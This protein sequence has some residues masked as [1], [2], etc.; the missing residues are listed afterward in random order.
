M[1][2]RAGLARAAAP[3]VEPATV[4]QAVVASGGQR[5]TPEMV[6]PALHALAERWAR[7]YTGTFAFMVDMREAAAHGLSA[8]Q[9][10]GVLNCLLAD[11]RRAATTGTTPTVAEPTGPATPV[12][13][14]GTYTV[15]LDP[16]NPEH[17]RR[18]LRLRDGFANRPGS[19]VAAYLAGPDNDRS[20][21]GF[22]TVEGREFHVWRRF[23]NGSPMVVEALAAL[24]HMDEPGLA[25]E[26][27]AMASGRCY[28]CSRTLT[29]PASLHRG[30]GPDC[31]A[32]LGVV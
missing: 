12:V 15:V 23:A 5:F 7:E 9:A 27:Y 21:N 3:A 22:A 2:V 20:Y 18:T 16:K 14:N 11:V 13:P 30:L 17:T 24:L 32:V 28:R 10:K 26:A 31:A 6:T 29:V 19:Q 25:G 1:A 4:E 8:G